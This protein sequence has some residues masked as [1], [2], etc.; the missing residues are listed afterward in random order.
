MKSYLR[1]L[2]RPQKDAKDTLK[3]YILPFEPKRHVN[4]SSGFFED[5]EDDLIFE[6]D[7]AKGGGNSSINMKQNWLG[8]LINSILPWNNLPDRKL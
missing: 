7:K 2:N 5:N 1:K 8:L 4:L 6:G 3:N